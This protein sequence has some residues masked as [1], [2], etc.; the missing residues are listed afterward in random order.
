VKTT[1]GMPS[2]H[3]L[4]AVQLWRAKDLCA[5]MHLF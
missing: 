2:N 4:A 1:A 5:H 3:K